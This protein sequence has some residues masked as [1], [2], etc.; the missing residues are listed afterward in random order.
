MHN[1]HHHEDLTEVLHQQGLKVT[2]LRLA[3]LKVFSETH[4]P[5]SAEEL[6]K[7]LKKVEFDPATLFRCLKKFEEG[8]IIKAVDLGEGFIR[9]ERVCVEHGHHHHI[10]CTSCK[11]I[12]IVPFCIPKDFENHFLKIGYKNLTHRMDF[13]GICGAC[14]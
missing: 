2:P 13:F 6:T 12:E 10:Q 8:N 3:M 11:K 9:Y 1:H 4:T 14:S 5:L 7:K